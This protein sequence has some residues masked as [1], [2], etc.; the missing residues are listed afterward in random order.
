MDNRLA[1][2]LAHFRFLLAFFF[3]VVYFFVVIVCLFV[4]ASNTAAPVI[5]RW[6]V[7]P[8]KPLEEQ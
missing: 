2:L 8:A 5:S 6:Q 3:F 7:Q 1:S 4:F